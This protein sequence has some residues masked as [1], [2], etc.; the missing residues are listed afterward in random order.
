MAFGKKPIKCKL[1]DLAEERSVYTQTSTLTSKNCTTAALRGS[2]AFMV[3][4]L[5]IEE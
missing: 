1:G 3:P 5:I 4:E 2:L